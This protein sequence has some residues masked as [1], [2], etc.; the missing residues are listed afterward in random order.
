MVVK[1]IRRI[2]LGAAGLY[3]F[4]QAAQVFRQVGL[5]QATAFPAALGVLFAVMAIWG[6]SG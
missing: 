5:T 6:K 1:T 2:V 3:F 4:L